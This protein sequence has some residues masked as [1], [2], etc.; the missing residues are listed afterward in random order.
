MS[1]DWISLGTLKGEP[2]PAIVLYPGDRVLVSLHV[3]VMTQQEAHDLQS[4]LEERFPAV[5]FTMITGASQLAVQ[6]GEV[7]EP[8]PTGQDFIDRYAFP[9]GDAVPRDRTLRARYL[10]QRDQA[11]SELAQSRS[12]V[13]SLENQLRITGDQLTASHRRH[14]EDVTELRRQLEDTV[15]RKCSAA[16]HLAA[17]HRIEVLQQEIN[18][19]GAHFDAIQQEYRREIEQLKVD[20]EA[21]EATEDRLRTENK[22]LWAALDEAARQ[23]RDM[24]GRPVVI[25]NPAPREDHRKVTKERTLARMQRDRLIVAIRNHMNGFCGRNT[26]HLHDVVDMVEREISETRE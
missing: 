21:A 8:M 25:N 23:L 17:E 18:E 14:D 9:K 22:Q 15:G 26:A 10:R 3:P 24:L 1:D 20:K 12:R 11:R 13:L 19:S 2:V 16:G 5:A 4:K 6:R 7:G